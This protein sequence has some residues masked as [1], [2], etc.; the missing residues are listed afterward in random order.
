MWGGIFSNI[1]IG[2]VDWDGN[3]VQGEVMTLMALNKAMIGQDCQMVIRWLSSGK[4]DR[5]RF[6]R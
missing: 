5:P 4:E 3:I 1:E 6:G 2:E